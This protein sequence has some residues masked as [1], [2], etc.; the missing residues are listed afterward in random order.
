MVCT[1]LDAGAEYV[2]DA[3]LGDLTLEP[4]KELLAGRTVMLQVEGLDEVLLGRGEEGAELGKVH[5][6]LTVVVL[7]AASDP[8]RRQHVG[9]D[10]GFERVFA[11]VRL[12]H[13]AASASASLGARPRA[14][15]ISPS[16]SASSTWSSDSGAS[17]AAASR[18]SS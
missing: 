13:S 11:G 7:G 4:G 17:F 9:H 18:T 6:V 8:A 16:S 2:D 14:P 12:A 5:G 3:A 10:Q 15:A 1:M